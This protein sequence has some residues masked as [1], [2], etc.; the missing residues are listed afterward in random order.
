M[1]G[2][3]KYGIVAIIGR[4]NTG[5]ST[6]LNAILQQKV[7]ITSPLPQTTRRNISAVYED[8]RESLF[9]DTPGVLGS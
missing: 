1:S 6:L 7:T 3:K 2:K 8:E 4:P 9:I 5:K